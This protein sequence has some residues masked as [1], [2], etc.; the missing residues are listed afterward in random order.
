MPF[1]LTNPQINFS[2]ISKWK[3]II[4]VILTFPI[5]ILPVCAPIPDLELAG[6]GINREGGVSTG[7][8][9]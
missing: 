7:F 2:V 1:Q 8:P 5:S 3:L 4:K 6:P 9:G